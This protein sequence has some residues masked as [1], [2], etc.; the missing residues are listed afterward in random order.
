MSLRIRSSGFKDKKTGK[1]VKAVKIEFNS[2]EQNAL[3]SLVDA[4]GAVKGLD[5]GGSSISCGSQLGKTWCHKVGDG[6]AEMF[7]LDDADTVYVLP[8]DDVKNLRTIV[9]NLQAV[10]ENKDG[11]DVIIT[12]DD[13]ELFE[14]A[15]E[16]LDEYTE[17]DTDVIKVGG[18]QIKRSRLREAAN[19]LRGVKKEIRINPHDYY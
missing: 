2:G 14:N 7:E 10:L 18:W 11:K 1:K 3:K 12:T 5:R 19:F 4:V 16:V 13:I 9:E 15:S 8:A 17:V 6:L